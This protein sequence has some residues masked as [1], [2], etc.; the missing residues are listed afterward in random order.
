MTRSVTGEDDGERNGRGASHVSGTA[1]GLLVPVANQPVAKG[2]LGTGC[3]TRY[4][5]QSYWSRFGS[6][7]CKT[8]TKFYFQPV[9][10]VLSVVPV[11][12]KS[13]PISTKKI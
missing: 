3:F 11:F 6:T 9:L 8:G 5:R 1:W 12:S 13:D 2:T 10:K 7:G 4:Y